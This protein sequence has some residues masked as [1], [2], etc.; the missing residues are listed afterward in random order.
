MREGKEGG[1]GKE[2]EG[3]RGRG[4]EREREGEEK[5]IASFL[6]FNNVQI[7]GG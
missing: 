6:R 1:R 3:E 2:R 5:E 7:P 4:K